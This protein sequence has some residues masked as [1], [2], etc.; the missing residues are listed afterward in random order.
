MITRVSLKNF[1][2]HT[3]TEIEAAPIS[4]FIGPNNSGKSSVF[5][6]LLSLRQAAVAARETLFLPVRRQS[7][8]LE[9]PYLFAADAVIDIGEFSEALRV[10][11]DKMELGLM[12]FLEPAKPSSYASPVEVEFRVVIRDNHLVSH[13]GRVVYSEYDA[14]WA[15]SE[16]EHPELEIRGGD[17]PGD[18]II[19]LNVVNH[20]G[21]IEP[22]TRGDRVPDLERRMAD[23]PV[24]LLRSVHCIYPL[25]GSEE[26]GYPLPPA[27]PKNLERLALPDRATALASILLYE[28]ELAQQLSKW[29]EDLVGVGIKVKVLEGP[30]LTI[31]TKAM[32]GKDAD[33]LFLNEGSGAN[34]LP[35]ILIPIGLAPQNETILL[36]EPEAHLHPYGQSHLMKLLLKVQKDKKLQ[37]FIETHSEH[38]LHALL[39]AV[40]KGTLQ[41]SDLAIFYFKNVNGEAQV[42]RLEVNE[43][44]QVAGGLPDFFDQSLKE[45]TEYL[46]ALEKS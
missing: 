45:L 13:K 14:Q 10:G 21:L 9:Q 36:S 11:Q 31:R 22:L 17:I 1:K 7:T 20:F 27:S 42:R 33:T 30:R 35:F 18:L 25:R 29:L 32:G 16:R 26:A 12:G 23:G 4:V 34:Q 44:G 5:Q 3:S 2:L 38:V 41:K 37:Y 40:A 19:H 6:A 8:S 15:W 39:H 28:D 46:E 43:Q 24:S